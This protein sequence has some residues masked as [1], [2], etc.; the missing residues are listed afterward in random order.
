MNYDFH[1]Q[2]ERYMKERNV[3]DENEA[4]K[5]LDEFIEKYNN[6]ELEPLDTP[7]S[8]AYDLLEEAERATSIKKRLSLVEKAIE[9]CPECVD[10]HLAY[11]EFIEDPFKIE[12][13]LLKVVEDEKKRLEKEEYFTKENIGHFYGIFETRPFMKAL[14]ALTVLYLQ[15]GK[16]QKALL[17]AKE[18]IRLN[19][20]DNLGARFLLFGLYAFM[21]DE[22]ALD[23]LKEKYEYEDLHSLVA[24]LALAIKRSDY[25]Q[26][27][28]YLAKIN[29]ANKNLIKYFQKKNLSSAVSPGY[30][31]PGDASEVYVLVTE[32]GFLFDS[33]PLLAE[34]I[35]R[36]GK[37]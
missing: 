11:L 23:S 10:A 37:I 22:K 19:E 33:T 8:K 6:K 4:Q 32:F 12:S 3:T 21:E 15:S 26:A 5:V 17:V 29:K 25:E 9:T 1:E 28:T 2:L 7:M 16:Y 35:A 30:Y 14:Q 27:K 20:N 36:E 24:Y 18:M 34:Y 13:Y 31:R